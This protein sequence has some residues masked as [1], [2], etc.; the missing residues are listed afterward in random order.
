MGL[1]DDRAG[2][3]YDA[4]FVSRAVSTGRIFDDIDMELDAEFVQCLQNQNG[5]NLTAH[6]D[7]ML[8]AC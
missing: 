8:L 3:T 7:L 4:C 1:S 5:G 2:V 6:A